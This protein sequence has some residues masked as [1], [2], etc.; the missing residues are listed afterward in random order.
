VLVRISAAKRIRDAAE[1]AARR[2]GEESI[3]RERL[4]L[5][6]AESRGG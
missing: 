6:I 1:R 3:S 2:A 5:A 4:A